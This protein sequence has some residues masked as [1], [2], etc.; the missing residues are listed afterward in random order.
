MHALHRVLQ[1]EAREQTLG[2]DEEHLGLGLWLGV[3]ARA[4]ARA[5]VRVRVKTLG[6]DEEHLGAGARRVERAKDL[7]ATPGRYT[8]GKCGCAS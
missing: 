8:P 4:R 3:R 6:R 5:R 1:R 2:R 7:S